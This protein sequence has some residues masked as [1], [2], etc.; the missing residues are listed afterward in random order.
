MIAVARLDN[1]HTPDCYSSM[2]HAP[3][4]YRTLRTINTIHR[5]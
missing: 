4:I 5:T 1:S 3:D 2:N